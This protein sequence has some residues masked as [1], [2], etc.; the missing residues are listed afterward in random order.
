MSDELQ[1]WERVN[2]DLWR[3]DVGR[4]DARQKLKLAHRNLRRARESLERGDPDE[5]LS[6]AENVL[7]NA[8]DA[9]LAADG[10]RIRGKT[11]SHRARFDYPRLPG[12]FAE[13]AKRI[14]RIRRLRS[15]VTYDQANVVSP[16]EA[17]AAVNLAGELLAAVKLEQRR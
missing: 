16:E 5:A 4:E 11:G 6:K 14:D 13:H 1:V 10:Y 15:T 8:A 2:A 17:A 7:V 12:G 3:R 9:A